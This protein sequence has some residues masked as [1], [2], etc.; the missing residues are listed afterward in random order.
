[1]ADMNSVFCALYFYVYKYTFNTKLI[2]NNA[3]LY[4]HSQC[5]VT[6]VDKNTNYKERDDSECTDAAFLLC[7]ATDTLSKR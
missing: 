1:M 4:R 6:N 7:T 5:K 3:M 2:Y